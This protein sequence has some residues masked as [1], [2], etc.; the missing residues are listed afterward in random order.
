MFIE[1]RCVILV[2]HFV[3]F[4]IPLSLI[5]FFTKIILNYMDCCFCVNILKVN[6]MCIYTPIINA[7]STINSLVHKLLVS[8]FSEMFNDLT[9]VYVFLFVKYLLATLKCYLARIKVVLIFSFKEENK[10]KK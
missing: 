7:K 3:N 6:Y 9:I 2:T 5:N 1:E 8:K 10:K 4:S